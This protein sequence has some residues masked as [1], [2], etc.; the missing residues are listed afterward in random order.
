MKQ[1]VCFMLFYSITDNLCSL[2]RIYSASK[3][4]TVF[5]WLHLRL[6]NKHLTIST[7]LNHLYY[8]SQ[9]INSKIV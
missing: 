8:V 5:F 6:I 2:I 9:K 4:V 7:G 3:S 1:F